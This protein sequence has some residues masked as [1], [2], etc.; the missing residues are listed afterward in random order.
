MFEPVYLLIWFRFFD[1]FVAM[2]NHVDDI[3][4]ML[5]SLCSPPLH[6]YEINSHLAPIGD[7]QKPS[8]SAT[9]QRFNKSEIPE[10]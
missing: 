6:K 1:L 3:A 8:S 9:F 2:C 7:L 4:D 10:T 5:A